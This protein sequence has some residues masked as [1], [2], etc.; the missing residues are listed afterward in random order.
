MYILGTLNH[1]HK[2]LRV[3]AIVLGILTLGDLIMFTLM[4][5]YQSSL[6]KVYVQAMSKSID[7]ALKTSDQTTLDAFNKLERRLKCCGANGPQDYHY[8]SS[9]MPPRSCFADEGT[10]KNPYAI[11]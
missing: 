10:S 8:N 2:W 5:V 3:Y 4:L 9:S 7:E 11:G 6:N 1:R